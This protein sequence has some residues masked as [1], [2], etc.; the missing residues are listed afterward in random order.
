MPTTYD[1]LD[2]SNMRRGLQ[3]LKLE[4]ELTAAREELMKVNARLFDEKKRANAAE[5]HVSMRNGI[6]VGKDSEIMLL[7]TE[8]ES[9]QT[10]KAL[11][12]GHIHEAKGHLHLLKFEEAL[13]VLESATKEG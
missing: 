13:H 3:I 4:E 12:L 11:L 7:K 10:E 2:K 9:A 6:I 5:D 1:E 8:R